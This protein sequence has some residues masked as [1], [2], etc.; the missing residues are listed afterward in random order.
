MSERSVTH[1]V[2][3]GS[4][5]TGKTVLAR[6][7]AEHFDTLWV[8]EYGREYAEQ[9]GG[10]LSASDIEAIAHGQIQ[11]ADDYLRRL[12]TRIGPEAPLGGEPI[13]LIHDTDLV[14]TTVYAEQYYGECPPWIM[15]A[16]RIRLGNLYLLCDVDLPWEAD[17]V[18]DLPHAREE[19]HTRFLQR[20]EE[21]RA[22]T[23]LV[24]ES[25]SERLQQAIA[26]I[27]W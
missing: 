8:P 2:V 3:T 17:G 20:L 4:E 27:A 5:S 24:R 11:L 13:L 19:V 12:A 9:R 21:F 7:L 1:V 18:R 22:R 10:I 25:G 16:A 6:E 26:A 14:S 23:V 15:S